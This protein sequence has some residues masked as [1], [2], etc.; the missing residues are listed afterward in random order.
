MRLFKEQLEALAKLKGKTGHQKVTVEHVHVYQ[1]GQA[2]VGPVT[3][4]ESALQSV[5]RSGKQ[6]RN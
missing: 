6:F 1:G 3:A 5:P 2:I 4:A